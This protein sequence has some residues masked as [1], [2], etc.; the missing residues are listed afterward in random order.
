YA[1]TDKAYAALLDLVT[2]ICRRNGIKKLVWSTRK[3][4]A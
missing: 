1:V 2:D 4:T 3:A